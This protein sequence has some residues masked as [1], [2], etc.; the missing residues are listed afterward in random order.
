MNLIDTLKNWL[1]TSKKEIPDGYCPNCWGFQEY[2]G[3]FYEAVKNQGI[4]I[5]NLDKNKGWVQDYADKYLHKIKSNNHED[6]T[7]VCA[8]CKIK[9]KLK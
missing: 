2:S 9:Y 4:T 8:Q 5:D 6:E 7:V 1:N 3:N